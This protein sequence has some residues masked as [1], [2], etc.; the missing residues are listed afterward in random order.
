M[1]LNGC[2]DLVTLSVFNFSLQTWKSLFRWFFHQKICL[3][4]KTNNRILLG[5]LIWLFCTTLKEKRSFLLGWNDKRQHQAD[6]RQLS[7]V[8]FGCIIRLLFFFT[9]VVQ[10]HFFFVLKTSLVFFVQKS[11]LDIFLCYKNKA[12]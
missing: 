2:S 7:S 6:C 5:N 9:C 8:L 3:C 11:S 4:Q 12:W 10:L 1:K